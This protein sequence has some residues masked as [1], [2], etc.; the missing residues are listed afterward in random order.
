MLIGN[1]PFTRNVTDLNNNQ[2]RNDL[3][4]TTVDFENE[5][6]GIEKLNARNTVIVDETL[7]VSNIFVQYAYN[8]DEHAYY[9]RFA[10]AVKG[11]IDEVEYVRS[12]ADGSIAEATFTV[13]K[14]YQG[15]MAGN[16]VY[17]YDD[18]NNM[19]TTDVSFKGQYYWA[20]YTARF[21]NAS[22]NIAKDLN[23]S[24][25]INGELIKAR[26]NV[27]L[28]DQLT[29]QYETLE[30]EFDIIQLKIQIIRIGIHVNHILLIMY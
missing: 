6:N 21:E 27:S 19:P 16:D 28:F 17:Y 11:S 1:I 29:S 26:D 10:T 2:N 20:C 18:V 30:E 13:E 12:F 15:I 25:K 5:R 9:L 7:A 24:L 22:Q 4:E 8:E 14:V 3:V 23:V